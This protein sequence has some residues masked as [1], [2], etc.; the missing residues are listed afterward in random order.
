MCLVVVVVVVLVLLFAPNFETCRKMM[1]RSTRSNREFGQMLS[2]G[3]RWWYLRHYF[4][5][6]FKSQQMHH[7]SSPKYAEKLYIRQ[8]RITYKAAMVW[9]ILMSVHRKTESEK[10]QRATRMSY[11]RTQGLTL[12]DCK[13]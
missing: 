5:Q 3:R 4:S 8:R 11:G 2:R 7:Q 12:D 10:G 6:D 9:Q 1:G 13:A